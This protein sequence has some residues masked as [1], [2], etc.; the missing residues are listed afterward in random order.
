VR[1]PV[2]VVIADVDRDGGEETCKLVQGKS[3]SRRSCLHSPG[4]GICQLGYEISGLHNLPTCFAQ[5]VFSIS[6]LPH[7]DRGGQGVFIHTDVRDEAAVAALAEQVRSR[8]V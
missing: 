5:H 1:H 8:Y 7:A 6:N 3:A 4:G 2:T